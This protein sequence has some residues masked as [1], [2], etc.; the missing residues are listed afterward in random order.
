MGDVFAAIFSLMYAAF[1]A[2]NNAQFMTDIGK[3]QNAAVQIFKV[4]D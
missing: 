4:L 2:G 1:G 3:A